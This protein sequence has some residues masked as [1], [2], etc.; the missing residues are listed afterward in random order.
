M[1]Y[2]TTGN[3]QTQALRFLNTL[4]SVQQTQL[5]VLVPYDYA[6]VYLPTFEK[7]IAHY[8]NSDRFM[9]FLDEADIV[10]ISDVSSDETIRRFVSYPQQYGFEPILELYISGLFIRSEYRQLFS[11]K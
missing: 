3:P 9:E 8:N 1:P 11:P 10:M 2:K 6:G 7:I 4:D 5:T